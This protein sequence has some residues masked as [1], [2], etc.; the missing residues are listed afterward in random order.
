MVGSHNI[1]KAL[2]TITSKQL[3]N[4]NRKIVERNARR[5]FKSAS[6][7]KYITAT[8]QHLNKKKWPY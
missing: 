6:T 5:K 2:N 4:P 1:K 8:K 7:R 3:Q